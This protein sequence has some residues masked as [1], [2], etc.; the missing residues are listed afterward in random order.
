MRRGF[1]IASVTI[2]PAL[3]VAFIF[4]TE[5]RASPDEESLIEI[6]SIGLLNALTFALPQFVWLA[7]TGLFHFTSRVCDTALVAADIML[8]V[9]AFVVVFQTDPFA[10]SWLWLIYWPLAIIASVFTGIVARL[11]APKGLT[12]R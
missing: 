5:R 1:Q 3:V 2:L 4:F 8:L 11:L 6:V 7:A 10:G 12:T 9:F